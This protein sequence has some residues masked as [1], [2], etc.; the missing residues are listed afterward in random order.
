MGLSTPSIVKRIETAE[1]TAMEPF[2]ILA[3]QSA[4]EIATS[5][6]PTTENVASNTATV[7]EKIMNRVI[8]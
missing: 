8:V 3:L 5:V 4:S 1:E 6:K 2:S 7:I